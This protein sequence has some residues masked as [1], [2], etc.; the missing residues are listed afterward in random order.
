MIPKYRKLIPGRPID[1]T[2]LTDEE[3]KVYLDY[4]RNPLTDFLLRL[5]DF[6]VESTVPSRKCMHCDKRLSNFYNKIHTNPKVTEE[7]IRAVDVD[8]A[9]WES[10][11]TH[12]KVLLVRKYARIDPMVRRIAKECEGKSKMRLRPKTTTTSYRQEQFIIA[13]IGGLDPVDAY[14]KHVDKK[15]TI[16]ESKIKSAAMLRTDV[17]REKAEKMKEEARTEAIASRTEVLEMLTVDCRDKNINLKDRHNAISMIIK[18]EAWNKPSA[19]EITH[20]SQPII[21]E[22]VVREILDVDA[23][24]IEI[25]GVPLIPEPE[26]E[27]SEEEIAKEEKFNIV[28]AEEEYGD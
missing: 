18:L 14:I 12:D 9:L 4:D 28:E 22:K 1:L 23:S 17:V 16:G 27:P 15:A 20:K 24:V 3:I 7:V 19:V 13:V 2:E 8:V 21:I 5:Y 25:D 10:G 11:D 6:H 26:D